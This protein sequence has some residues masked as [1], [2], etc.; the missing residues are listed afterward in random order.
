MKL[1]K[2]KPHLFLGM[3]HSGNTTLHIASRSRHKSSVVQKIFNIQPCFVYERNQR[4]ETPLHIAA[5]VGDVN[6][7]KLLFDIIV[8]TLNVKKEFMSKVDGK[9]MNALHY[10]A[11]TTSD[12][13]N[14]VAL[15]S[16]DD[17]S[18]AYKRDNDG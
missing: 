10:A 12:D 15:L 18:L 2:E 9:Q 4:G 16:K 6:V 5:T 3:S 8:E 14:I 17:V 13:V 7:V 11:T 1:A